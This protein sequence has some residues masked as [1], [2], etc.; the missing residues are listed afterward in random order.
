LR[1]LYVRAALLIERSFQEKS[2]QDWRADKVIDRLLR[3]ILPANL[4]DEIKQQPIG[5][6]N[7]AVDYLE[8]LFL[9]EAGM[10]G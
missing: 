6:I 3:S 7:A 8:H 4:V 10:Q 2:Y 9:R 5:G 1:A